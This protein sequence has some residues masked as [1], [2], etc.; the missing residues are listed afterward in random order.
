MHCGYLCLLW[1]FLECVLCV[2]LCVVEVVCVSGCLRCAHHVFGCA[3]F[4]VMCEVRCLSFVSCVCAFSVVQPVC[5]YECGV[6]VHDSVCG[7]QCVK[8]VL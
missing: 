6:S 3:W 4:C 1:L 5:G 8:C 2:A 7:L